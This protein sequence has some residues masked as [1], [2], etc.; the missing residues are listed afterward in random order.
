MR[1]LGFMAAAFLLMGLCIDR[2]QAQSSDFYRI[3]SPTGLVILTFD[4][5]LEWR[6]EDET[7]PYAITCVVERL[8]SPLDAVTSMWS[9]WASVVS[10][11][12]TMRVHAIS[13]S[14]PPGM[15]FVPGGSFVMGDDIHD[16]LA[17]NEKPVR[18]VETDSFFIS[19]TPITKAEWDA[20]YK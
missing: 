1:N 5:H 15:A 20:V 18:D 6:I 8:G 12:G 7:P 9:R 10:T 11:T 2:V 3:T 17:N 14:V 4:G 13:F 16:N 19:R